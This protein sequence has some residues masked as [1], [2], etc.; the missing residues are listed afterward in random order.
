MNT[1]CYCTVSL[2]SCKLFTTD[3][4]LLTSA[5]S[6]TN[7]FFQETETLSASQLD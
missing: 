7:Q 5:P 4:S 2:S 1:D 6:P 3:L